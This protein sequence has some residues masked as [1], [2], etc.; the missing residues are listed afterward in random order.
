MMQTDKETANQIVESQLFE[1]LMAIS[2]LDGDEQRGAR[3]CAG[4]A[5]KAAADFG[6]VKAVNR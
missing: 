2:K 3:E 5:L 6:L 4:E 1:I